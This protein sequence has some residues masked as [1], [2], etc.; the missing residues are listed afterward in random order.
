MT[1]WK[2]KFIFEASLVCS[3]DFICLLFQH[4]QHWIIFAQNSC[5][6]FWTD[7][8]KNKHKIVVNNQLSINQKEIE[9]IK[10]ILEFP[11]IIQEID[12]K[13]NE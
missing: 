11:K 3:S 4:L 12:T 9:L 6:K 1:L 10:N 5:P 13:K 2:I 8:R 7:T